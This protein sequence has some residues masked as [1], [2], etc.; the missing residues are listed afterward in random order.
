LRHVPVLKEEVLKGLELSKGASVVDCTAGFGGHTGELW[1]QVM[2]G[3]RVVA[4]DRDE[5]A[6][7][8]CRELFEAEGKSIVCVQEN[9]RYLKKICREMDLEEVDAILI[10]CGTSSVQLE[11]SDRG[12]SFRTAGD[13][14]MR[15]DD[16]QEFTLKDC[17]T[18]LTE[19]ELADTIFLYGQERYSRRIAKAVKEAL[20]KGLIGNTLELA[21]VIRRSVPP[22]YRRGRIHPA[23]RSFQALRIRVNDE[24]ESLTEGLNAGIDLLSDH[25]RIA[26]I[27]F[28]SL[29]DGIAK[30]I[31]HQKE[32]E[33]LGCRLTKKPIV[34]QRQEVIQNPRSRS[35]KLRIFERIK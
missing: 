11:D 17:L 22:G 33:E 19:E 25:G 31:F 3:G 26:V 23:T 27:T 5:V 29:E 7:R 34:P 8:H 4:I 20:R 28:H 1:E 6:I 9:F 2:P 13:L 24:L 16:R 12:F 15:M 14:D 10:D 18:R 30:R 21:E 32:R 35:A